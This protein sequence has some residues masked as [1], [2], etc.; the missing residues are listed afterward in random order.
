MEII[1]Q[2]VQAIIYGIVALVALLVVLLIALSR[3]P[4][5]NPLH[6]LLGALVRPVGVMVAAGV[7]GVPVEFIPG[8]DVIYDI[9]AV[10]LIAFSWL[11]FFKTARGIWPQLLSKVAAAAPSGD[12]NISA[13]EYFA[14]AQ[15]A[16]KRKAYT[17]ALRWYRL[18]AERGHLAA[19]RYL[20]GA[21][22]E[23]PQQ[24]QRQRQ[25]DQRTRSANGAMSRA[26]A[27]E[28]LDLA[29]GATEQEISAAHTRLIKQFH[30]DKGGSAFFAKQLNTARDV[31]L[32]HQ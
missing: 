15:E 9:A 8:I 6:Q 22:T 26:E 4:K 13:G 31:L 23:Q 12:P 25:Q 32:G 19:K 21:D 3:M 30:P 17:E 10:V 5:D 1:A 28:I 11:K 14:R 2:I 18:A 27:L 7:V 29:V 20:E 16:T 24:Q